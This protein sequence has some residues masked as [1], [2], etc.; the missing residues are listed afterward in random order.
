MICSVDFN[1]NLS[2]STPAYDPMDT[3]INNGLSEDE[4]MA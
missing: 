4:I 2:Q 3:M 1:P